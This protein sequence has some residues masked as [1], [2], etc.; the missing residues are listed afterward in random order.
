M[1]GIHRY[2]LRWRYMS[3][4]AYLLLINHHDNFFLDTLRYNNYN[5]NVIIIIIILPMPIYSQKKSHGNSVLRYISIYVYLN[6]VW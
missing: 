4:I 6:L 1:T 3:R 2:L 5:E